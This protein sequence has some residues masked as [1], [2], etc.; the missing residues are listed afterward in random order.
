MCAI[1]IATKERSLP[2]ISYRIGERNHHK[3][4]TGPD[5]KM[6]GVHGKFRLTIGTNLRWD[7]QLAVPVRD[8]FLLKIHSRSSQ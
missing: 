2:M 5:M 7:G 3:L 4:M 8:I 6:L 1:E